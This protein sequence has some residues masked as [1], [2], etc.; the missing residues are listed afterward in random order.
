MMAKNKISMIYFEYQRRGTSSLRDSLTDS[1][2]LIE[3]ILELDKT[4]CKRYSVKSMTTPLTHKQ[5]STIVDCL[6]KTTELDNYIEACGILVRRG[7]PM[8]DWEVMQEIYD[9][10]KK[11]SQGL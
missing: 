9:K 8:P 5:A 1:E 2:Q 6:R 7:K 10:L 4:Y 11:A 3:E